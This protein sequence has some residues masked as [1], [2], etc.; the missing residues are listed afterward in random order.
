[1][2]IRDSFGALL[3]NQGKF[4]EAE[5]QFRM[6]LELDP[7]NQLAKKNLELVIQRQR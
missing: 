2:C 3:G 1:M 5:A 4:N 6:A 7:D